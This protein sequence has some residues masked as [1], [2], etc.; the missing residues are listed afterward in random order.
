MLT[1]VGLTTLSMISLVTGAVTNIV[2]DPILIF[3]LFG[4]PAMGIKGAAIATVIGQWLGAAVALLLNKKYNPCVHFSFEGFNIKKEDVIAI[5][6]IGL[7]TMIM[8]SVGSLMI[9]TINTILLPLSSSAVAF[10]GVYYKLQNFVMMP[11]NGLGQAVL[12]IAGFNLGAKN[13]RRTKEVYRTVIPY[14][15]IYCL[16]GT[17][18]TFLFAPELLRLFNDSTK[19][20]EIGTPALRIIALTF[21]LGGFTIVT[22]YYCS[23]LG[24]AVINMV[25]GILR[26]YVLLIPA[27]IFLVSKLGISYS[28]YAFWIAEAGAAVYSLLAVN[29]LLNSPELSVVR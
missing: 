29:N 10:F 7:P 23:G 6:K 27:F 11:I 20:L 26:Q 3:G 16:C 15:I 8:Q 22:G 9:T 21:A 28:W 14:T 13:I 18:I 5:Y 19:M 1:A 12:P 4:L 2:L 24:H 25:G 17:A